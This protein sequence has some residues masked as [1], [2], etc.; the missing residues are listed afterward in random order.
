MPDLQCLIT[1]FSCF[2]KGT[3]SHWNLLILA[4]S[5]DIYRDEKILNH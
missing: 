2:L 5:H 1:Q 3:L 4:M